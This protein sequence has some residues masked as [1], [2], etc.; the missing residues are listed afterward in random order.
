MGRGIYRTAYEAAISSTDESNSAVKELMDRMKTLEEAVGQSNMDMLNKPLD[1]SEL[2][3]P[4]PERDI[5]EGPAW[6]P[7]DVD[8]SISQ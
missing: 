3:H 6:E 7:Y 1:P 8:A 2:D 5:Y 4:V